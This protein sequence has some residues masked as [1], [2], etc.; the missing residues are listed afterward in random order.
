MLKNFVLVVAG[1]ALLTACGGEK[2]ADKAEEPLPA[3]VYAAKDLEAALP[4][5]DEMPHGRK[6]L[7]Q[8]PGSKGC[9]APTAG[10]DGWSVHFEL[11]PA[12]P[13]DR[14]REPSFVVDQGALVSVTRLASETDATA[15]AAKFPK[16]HA[17]ETGPF[18]TKGE[19]K[20]DKSYGPGL[21]GEGKV[22]D[23]K[24]GGWSGHQFDKKFVL[25]WLGGQESE[26]VQD[27][28]VTV[29]YGRYLISVLTVVSGYDVADGAA[30]KLAG[31]LVDDYLERLG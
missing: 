17:K 25:F 3:K 20:A 2:P 7:K 8:C 5:L 6:L 15:R 16:S 18:E 29:A 4:S 11:E 1:V 27:A 12:S 28:S 13:I 14:D 26:P 19:Q 10:T 24:H 30:L 22:G 21:R 31:Q 23:A 9:V